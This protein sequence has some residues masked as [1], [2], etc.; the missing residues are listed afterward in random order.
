[1]L[2]DKLETIVFRVPIEV[3]SLFN[4]VLRFVI[5]VLDKEL[6]GILNDYAYI[7]I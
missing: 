4:E 2:V 3:E 1:M 7:Y 5:L 6:S